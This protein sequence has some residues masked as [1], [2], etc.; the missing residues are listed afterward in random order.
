[1]RL[2]KMKYHSVVNH[3]VKMTG[4]VYKHE[5]PRVWL[6]PDGR[7]ANGFI[8][9]HLPQRAVTNAMGKRD[10]GK[11]K[12][13]T[14]NRPDIDSLISGYLEG[15]KTLCVFERFY[16]GTDTLLPKKSYGPCD[17]YAWQAEFFVPGQDKGL[18][19]NADYIHALEY[20]GAKWWY[21]RD[22]PDGRQWLEGWSDNGLIGAVMPIVDDPTCSP[23]CADCPAP[24]P[25]EPPE[26]LEL[27][28]EPHSYHREQEQALRAAYPSLGKEPS[29]WQ[30]EQALEFRACYA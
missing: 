18:K 20:A 24:G 8:W 28:P 1:M 26:E 7:L 3:L 16:F 12:F 30:A 2:R 11:L 9:L 25:P 15:E 4:N 27:C 22:H 13:Q 14:D 10:K 23:T 5:E 6:Y 19:V 29:K 21:L 17:G